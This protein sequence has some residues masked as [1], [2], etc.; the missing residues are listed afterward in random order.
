MILPQYDTLPLKN[1]GT[2]DKELLE[3]ATGYQVI[4]GLSGGGPA[5]AAAAIY[6]DCEFSD[7]EAK[8]LKCSV[9]DE[10]NIYIH[11]EKVC[12]IRFR[13]SQVEFF[14]SAEIVLCKEEVFGDFRE[15]PD[16]SVRKHGNWK[17]YTAAAGN[18]AVPYYLNLFHCSFPWLDGTG[19]GVY[20]LNAR[21]QLSFIAEPGYEDV[22]YI[23]R[24]TEFGEIQKVFD[25]PAIDSSVGIQINPNIRSQVKMIPDEIRLFETTLK[26]GYKLMPLSSLER[27]LSDGEDMKI[28]Q[29]KGK[30]AVI[31]FRGKIVLIREKL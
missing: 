30:G 11:L 14:P 8:F 10:Y 4:A 21:R 2:S 20:L 5:A 29:S 1:I 23:D 25:Y 18:W 28:L 24:I 19:K 17:I 26:L 31:D 6:N 3:S 7:I 13:Y 12:S 22:Y 9:R 16:I 27:R 15:G